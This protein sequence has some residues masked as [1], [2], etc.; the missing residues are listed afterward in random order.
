MH[1]I[2][3]LFA[4]IHTMKEKILQLKQEISKQV[5]GHK[6]MIDALLIALFTE[7]HVLLEGMP[8]LG[9]AI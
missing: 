2:Y 4:T 7:G 1:I 9:F 5:I 8:G 3:T 6:E